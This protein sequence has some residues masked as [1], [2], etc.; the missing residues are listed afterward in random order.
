M[1]R[2]TIIEAVALED[3]WAAA[4][5]RAFL[6]VAEQLINCRNQRDFASLPR[7][8][9]MAVIL[10]RVEHIAEVEGLYQFLEYDADSIED[11]VAFLR[12]I[13]ADRKAAM[14]AQAAKN[15]EGEWQWDRVQEDTGE[16]L[17]TFCLAHRQEFEELLVQRNLEPDAIADSSSAD[18]EIRMLALSGN[19][20]ALLALASDAACPAR[21]KAVTALYVIAGSAACDLLAG[22]K[23]D[24]KDLDEAIFRAHRSPE[25]ALAAWANDASQMLSSPDPETIMG[26][27]GGMATLL[28]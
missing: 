7:L 14:L 17:R 21:D 26:W 11:G 3:L 1:T 4:D 10:F 5:G 16:L 22:K 12:E 19:A 23:A 9:K 24:F 2:K 15:P 6:Q 25:P 13:G 28:E 18:D 27:M 20:S 8:G